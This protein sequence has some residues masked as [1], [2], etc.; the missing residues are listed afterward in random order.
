[1][2][3]VAT[4]AHLSHFRLRIPPGIL[5]SSAPRMTFLPIAERELIVAAR[6]PTT[7][8]VR[9]GAALVAIL[10]AFFVLVFGGSFGGAQGVGGALFNFLSIGTF[11][12]VLGSGVFLTADSIA[13][14]RREGTLGLLFLTD[15]GGFDV[16]TGKLLACGLNAIYGVL[17]VLPIIATAWFIGGVTGGEFV[18]TALVLLN[19]LWL[20]LVIGLWISCEARTE[21]EALG[22]TALWILGIAVVPAGLAFVLHTASPTH[23][24]VNLLAS[25]LDISPLSG[26][27]AARD[28]PYRTDPQPF[29]TSLLLNHLLAW[30]FLGLAS[31]R[32]RKGWR[33]DDSSS[34]A[35]AKVPASSK[36]PNSQESGTG[37]GTIPEPVAAAALHRRLRRTINPVM[38]FVEHDPRISRLL[39]ICVGLGCAGITIALLTPLRASLTS[40]PYTIAIAI[41]LALLP[42][43]VLFA[44]KACA[45]FAN[46]RRDG[47]IELLLT[48]PINDFDIVRGQLQG[49]RQLFTKPIATFALGLGVL[50]AAT[51]LL[52]Q[53]QA[54]QFFNTAAGFATVGIVLVYEWATLVVDLQAMAWLGFWFALVEPKPGVAFAK[55]VLRAIVFPM[56]VFCLPNLMLNGLQMSWAR[57]RFRMN[58]KSILQGARDPWPVR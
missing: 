23:F 21:A 9:R 48:T 39:W 16:V 19:S 22:N 17:A 1:M 2:S 51:V 43:K 58:L 12:F 57:D 35:T 42:L 4:T 24:A 30:V 18:R 41:H 50:W 5:P 52:Y 49:L 40:D 14:E 46:G 55:T 3:P 53:S 29:W 28:L 8:R 13:S 20:S 45:F 36:G 10:A 32:L 15:L 7:F 38:A 25:L 6:R 37:S 47:T 56:V 27:R 34:D 33:R 26:L 11:L 44:W 54:S 31:R